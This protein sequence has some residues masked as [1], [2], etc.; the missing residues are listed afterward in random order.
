ML[1]HKNGKETYARS[2]GHSCSRQSKTLITFRIL[3]KLG[4][5][6][7]AQRLSAC[8]AVQCTV[9]VLSVQLRRCRRRPCAALSA[10][11]SP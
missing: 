6:G 9:S 4:S 2:Q 5:Y 10:T 7:V 11:C 3:L 8:A 1:D